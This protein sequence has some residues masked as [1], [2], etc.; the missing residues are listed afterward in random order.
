MD[1]FAAM[2]IFVRVAETGSF[3]AAAD[4]L[5][6][7]RSVVTR[8]IS[9][10]EAHLG[11][12]LIARS[13]RRSALTAEGAV[14]LEK[15]REILNLV[16]AAEGGVASERQAP[17]GPIR[18]AVP[19]SFGQRH[20]MPLLG[21]FATQYPQVDFDLE[22][23]DRR[24]N[25]IEEGVDLAIRV[26]GEAEPTHVVR[27]LSVCRMAVLASP[28]YLARHGTPRHPADLIRHECLGYTPVMRSRWPF[29][30]H[31]ERREFEVRGRLRA[32]NGDALMDAAERGL[33]IV[34]QPTFLAGR[35][36]REGRLQIVL[37]DFHTPELNIYAVFPGHRHVPH[38]V[39]VLVDFLAERIGP[40]PY[41]D[42]G[43]R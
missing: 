9:A 8:Q 20:L 18:V 22:F 19:M 17:R 32:N 4:Q 43:L 24:I 6:V 23:N 31:G 15:C 25:L 30:I 34:Y 42:A 26:T 3:T 28:D 35:S 21:E 14:Y 40:E 39:R 10:L 27:R 36:I 38:R 1:R 12:K 7:A 11:A 2:E 37:A 33:G 13:T 5:N 29:V 16:Q 41:W